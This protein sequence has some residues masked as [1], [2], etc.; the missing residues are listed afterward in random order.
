M[1][2]PPTCPASLARSNRPAADLLL[3]LQEEVAVWGAFFNLS[4]A[5][6]M[7]GELAGR[8]VDSILAYMAT[9]PTFAHDGAAYGMCDMSNN[10]KWMVRAGGS[11]C[12]G[13]LKFLWGRDEPLAQT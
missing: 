11:A 10:A 12:A 1:A 6:W 8:T 4:D 2:D 7:H 5:G 3:L 9:L 13:R